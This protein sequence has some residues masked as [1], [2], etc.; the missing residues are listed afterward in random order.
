MCENL[1]S[2]VYCFYLFPFLL[3]LCNRDVESNL[4]LKKN[5][6]FSVSCCHCNVNS[7][8][9]HDYTKITYLEAYNSAFKY[10]FICISEMYLDSKIF[11]ENNNP[12][13]LGYNLI[14]P[15][16]PSSYQLK[17]RWH[18]HLLFRISSSTN[19]E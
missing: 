1:F 13:I 15:D 18:L 7:I 16:C 6:E 4:G 5:L 3:L 12:N 10:D 11:S 9:D 19:F 2:L 17:K 14:K 8:L